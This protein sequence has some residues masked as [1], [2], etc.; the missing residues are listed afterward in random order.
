MTRITNADHVLNL[1]RARLERAQK[2]RKKSSA[3]T[4]G[5]KERRPSAIERLE[6][7]AGSEALTDAEIKKALIAGLL[8][9]E[10]GDNIVNDPKFHAVVDD[11]YAIL[12]REEDGRH[13]LETAHAQL[14]KP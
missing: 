10:L 1:L 11:I 4:S 12:A 6:H 14:L 2:S 5:T 7:V 9:E 3:S 13:L 8:S